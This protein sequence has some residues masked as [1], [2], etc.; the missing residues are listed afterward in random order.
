MPLP[1]RDP[2]AVFQAIR[3]TLKQFPDLRI[4]EVLETL[5]WPDAHHKNTHLFNIENKDLAA[6]IYRRLAEDSPGGIPDACVLKN[7][8]CIYCGN[9]ILT[10]V[11]IYCG[12]S[13]T[14]GA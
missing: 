12:S 14:S 5:S 1:D 9:S 3:D 6:L 11:C 2:E 8:V 7:G 4:G 13:I 10:G